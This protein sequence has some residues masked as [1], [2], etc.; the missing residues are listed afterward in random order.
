MIFTFDIADKSG[1]GRTQF[2]EACACV[3]AWFAGLFFNKLRALLQ[4]IEHAPR[5]VRWPRH[6]GPLGKT[7]IRHIA[8]PLDH[9]VAAALA[10][11]LNLVCKMRIA[12]RLKAEQPKPAISRRT[13][14][15]ET[16][17]MFAICW[18]RSD[19]M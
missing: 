10:V 13:R 17:N 1:R 12:A 19:C 14:L 11:A 15:R 2:H 3:A 6:A 8:V 4:H 9:D 16:C 18:N 7:G 5:E